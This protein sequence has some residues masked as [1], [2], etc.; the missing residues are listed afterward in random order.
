MRRHSQS[1]QV[2]RAIRRNPPKVIAVSSGKGGVGKTNIAANLSVALGKMHRNV[3]LL[4]ADMGLANVDVLLGLQ[5]KFNLSHIVS[6][7][8]DLEATLIDGPGGI[9]VI[10]AASGNF[11]MCDL[12]AAAQVAIIQ[13][14]TDLVNPPNTLVVDTPSGLSSSVGRFVQA[15]QYPIVV[16]CDEPASLTDAYAL[17]K[18]FSRHYGISHFQVVTNQTASATGGAALFNKLR[19]VTDTYL[20]VVINHLG[21]V[22]NDRHL[23]RSVQEQCAVVEKYPDSPSGIAFYKIAK[24]ID[25]LPAAQRPK[26]GIEFF[27]EHLL[28]NEQ[29][30]RGQVA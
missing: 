16:V 10:P 15:A 18:V 17:I 7:D 28:A 29:C 4:D 12:P 24:K 23:R 22:P 1:Q 19:R 11:N 3:C 8:V 9:R 20:D 26:G 30:L 13:A 6:G 5:P 21:D 27:F 2:T 25:E 14:F